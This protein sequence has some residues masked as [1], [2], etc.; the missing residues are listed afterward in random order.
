MKIEK[1]ELERLLSQYENTVKYNLTESGIHPLTLEELLSKEEI[2]KLVSRRIG[3]A[4]ANGSIKLRE[5]ISRLYAGAD[6]DNVLVTNGTAEA[7]FINIWCNLDPG[8]ELIL[9]VPN[10]MQMGGIARSLGITVKPFHLREELDWGP[11][12]EELKNL[13]TPQTKMIAVCNPNNPTGAV[14]SEEAMKEIVRLAQEADAWL[15]A[16]EVYRGAELD[17]KETPSFYG[18]YDK[19]IVCCGLSKAYALPGLRLGWMVGPKKIIEECWACH[20]YTAISSGLLSDHVAAIVLQP[21]QRMKVLKRN[22]QIVLEN[23]AVL[24]DWVRK[25]D[26]L[27]SFIPPRAGAIAFLKYSMNIN[28]TELSTKLREEKSL[29]IAPGDCFGMDHYLRIGLGSEKEYLL[30][31]LNLFDDVL[32]EIS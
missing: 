21:E 22:R 9:M 5:A 25:H 6:L 2:K 13:I 26:R 19:A 23:L 17:G 1:F 15:Y 31:G 32:A 8:D 20:D 28:S 18:L 7:N 16:D 10:Y 11:D 4:Q 24:Q 30:A 27:F 3:Y 29:F 14:L 12:L